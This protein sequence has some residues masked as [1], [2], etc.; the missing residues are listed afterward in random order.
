MSTARPELHVGDH[1]TDREDDGAPLVVVGK[2]VNRADQYYVEGMRVADYNP[3]YPD[4][5]DVVEAVYAK[6]SAVSLDTDEAYAFPR[7]RLELVEPIHGADGIEAN[8]GEPEP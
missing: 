8:V 7:S 6:R 2:S 1:V 4:D 5:D 3:S